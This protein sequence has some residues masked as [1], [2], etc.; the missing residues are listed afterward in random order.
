M[1]NETLIKRI[2]ILGCLV[3]VAALIPAVAS[4]ANPVWVKIAEN[5]I[6]DPANR[7]LLPGVQFNAKLMIGSGYPNYTLT[8]SMWA[9]DGAFSQVG[10]AGFGDANNRALLPYA[11]YQNMLYIGTGNKI[12]GGQLWKWSGAGDPSQITGVPWTGANNNMVIPLGVLN[13]RLLVCIANNVSG[14]SI[15]SFD[16]T[17]WSQLIGQGS[18]GTPTGPGFGDLHN[19]TIEQSHEVIYDGKLILP[20]MNGTSGLQ[21]YSYDGTDFTRIGQ[22]GA[23]SW[24]SFQKHGYCDVSYG[25][26][27]L[28]MGTTHR[29]GGPAQ[30]WSY[31]GS[32]WTQVSTSGA[33]ANTRT[34]FP[35]ARG[36]DLYLGTNNA[37]GG[38]VYKKTGGSLTPICD[39]GIGDTA[40]Y[41]VTIT[42]CNGS[43]F[44]LTWNLNGGQVYVTPIAPSIDKV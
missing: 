24:D 3:L 40:N 21:V 12:S 7:Y 34:Y 44:A 27:L 17:N 42:S 1:L 18:A 33:D 19:E 9:Y 6:T 15:Y 26:G 5:G 29:F 16:G 32:S 22:A 11:V 20:V 10:S 35:L 37:A 31:N 41:V 14:L 2:A 4:A 23:G 36:E 13:N 39:P 28:Y 38:R 25:E 43:L 8:T 30:L